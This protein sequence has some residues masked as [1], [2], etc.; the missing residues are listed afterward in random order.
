MDDGTVDWQNGGNG[1]SYGELTRLLGDGAMVFWVTNQFK[2]TAHGWNFEQLGPQLSQG[3]VER[4][5]AE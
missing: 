4:W 2:S 3:V 1:W 5:R